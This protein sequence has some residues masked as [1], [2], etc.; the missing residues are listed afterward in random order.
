MD[1][2]EFQSKTSINDQDDASSFGISSILIPLQQLE[3]KER[4][5]EHMHHFIRVRNMKL[6]AVMSLSF[7]DVDG[8][9]VPRRQIMI[10]TFHQKTSDTM[11]AALLDQSS[12]L[13]LTELTDHSIYNLNPSELIIRKFLQGNTSISRKGIAPIMLKCKF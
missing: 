8:K 2:K 7:L 9:K 3:R 5:L 4:Y 6:L 1:Y 13:Q 12:M 11:I 10:I